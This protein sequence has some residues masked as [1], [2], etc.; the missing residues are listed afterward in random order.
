MERDF[1]ILS[2]SDQELITTILGGSEAAGLLAAELLLEHNSSLSDLVKSDLEIRLR[3]DRRLS[4]KTHR[5]L[6][7]AA[8]LAQRSSIS[9]SANQKIISSSKDIAELL[10]PQMQNLSHEE[11]WI[12]FL[13]SYNRV[14]EWR[15]VGNSGIASVVFDQRVIIK[16]AMELLS[17]QFIIVHNHPSGNVNPS[18]EDIDVTRTLKEAAAP[19]NVN[20]VDHVILTS[21]ESYSFFAN[22]LL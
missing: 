3:M 21:R 2:L 7:L 19:F 16:R 17:T 5:M 11:C 8:E 6:L 13:T 22:G 9:Q 4:H 15:K 20:L 12:V 18:P 14:V 10:A 1:D